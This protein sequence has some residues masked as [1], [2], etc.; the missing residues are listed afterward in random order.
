MAEAETYI[1]WESTV[2]PDGGM[3]EGLMKDGQCHGKGVFQYA[4]GD[5]FEGEY[6]E[7][8]MDGLG[9]Y[10]WAN[11]S[12]FMGQWKENNMHGC[13]KKYYPGGAMEEGEWVEDDFVGDYTACNANEA[14]EAKQAA[15]GV[16]STSRMFMYK[17]DSEVAMK[18]G[19]RLDQHPLMYTSGTEFLMPGR[20]GEQYNVPKWAEEPMHKAA[21]IAQQVYEKFNIKMPSK[22]ELLKRSNALQKARDADLKRVAEERRKIELQKA[23]V[24]DEDDE[25]EDD[26]DDEEDEED[27]EVGVAGMASLSVSAL[28]VQRAFERAAKRAMRHLHKSSASRA[29]RAANAD[30]AAPPPPLACLSLAL[31]P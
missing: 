23:G 5:R 1:S 16:A 29:R 21:L 4:D 30:S 3:Y 28:R 6:S 9:V 8:L 13:G 26:D 20:L 27:E 24:D 31:R 25:D 14:E 7:G 18:N 15:I 22:E 11:G 19:M 2:Y 12:V 10:Q 17:P